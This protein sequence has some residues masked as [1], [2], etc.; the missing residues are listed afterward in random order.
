MNGQST[1]DDHLRQSVPHRAHLLLH[2]QRGEGPTKL[3]V[4]VKQILMERAGCRGSSLKELFYGWGHTQAITLGPHPKLTLPEREIC[5][6]S[7][8]TEPLA[9]TLA[10]WH[11][12][13]TWPLLQLR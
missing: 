10:C 3:T 1:G 12:T 7:T 13:T 4:A 6:A 5:G 11:S 2:K 8:E 9:L